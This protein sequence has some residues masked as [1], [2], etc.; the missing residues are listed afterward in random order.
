ML[1]EGSAD[2]SAIWIP[3][4]SVLYSGVGVVIMFFSQSS[5]CLTHDGP[6]NHIEGNLLPKHPVLPTLV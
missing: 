2:F 1:C 5:S 3:S 6:V 4:D